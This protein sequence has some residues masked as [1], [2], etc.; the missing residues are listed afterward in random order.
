VSAINTM[1]GQGQ[2]IGEVA[3]GP[4]A[5]ITAAVRVT[6]IESAFSAPFDYLIRLVCF[7]HGL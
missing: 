6:R 7:A 2:S 5:A 3:E 1:A 4:R